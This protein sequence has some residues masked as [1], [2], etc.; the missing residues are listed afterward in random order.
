MVYLD[1]T[2]DILPTDGLSVPE[3]SRM[4]FTSDDGPPAYQPHTHAP[5]GFQETLTYGF[6]TALGVRAACPDRAVIFV[7]GDNGLTQ[8]EESDSALACFHLRKKGTKFG[9][10]S[11]VEI[12][13][14]G[15]SRSTF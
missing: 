6:Q 3:L 4:G 13:P 12:A 11:L 14:R 15:R 5:K 8:Y 2:R 1:T 7:T 10:F 9:A